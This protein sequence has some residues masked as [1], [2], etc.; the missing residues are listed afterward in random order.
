MERCSA[1]GHRQALD[2][3]FD[4]D[5]LLNL[6]QK[7]GINLG[8]RVNLIDAHALCECIAHI[9]DAL[10]AGLPQLFLEHLAVLRFFVH[11]VDADLQP[12]QRFLERLLKGAAH[13]H[14][15]TDRFHLGR[16]AA[17]GCGEFLERKTRDFRHNIV[18]A[19]LETG[20]CGAPGD[21]VAQLVERITHRQ[22]GC[23]LGNRK[24]RGFRS[25]RRRTRHTRVHLDHHHATIDGVDGELN[26]G[27]AGINADFA[28]HGQRGV[29]QDL[30]F[31]VG[32]GLSRCHRDRV[33]GVHAHRVQIFDGADNDAVIHLVAHDFHLKLFPAQE[34]LFNQ[35]FIG[36]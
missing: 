3:Q 4:F 2:L 24:T 14:H 15:F 7:P 25:Q 31:L 17:V 9:P 23:D 5:D 8:Q 21:L 32:Q 28:Q 13:R 10:R 34:R 16:Q 36:G 30:I 6:H 29:A 12:A 19:G 27:T 22:L 33:T 11:A 35:E 20:G 26:V 1:V 18:N